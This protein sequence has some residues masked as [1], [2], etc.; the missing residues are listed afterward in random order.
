MLRATESERDPHLLDTASIQSADR[1]TCAFYSTAL[2]DSVASA[3]PRSFSAQRLHTST[4][5]YESVYIHA[6][7]AIMY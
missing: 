6:H 3:K 1:P 7:E 4:T 5:P 2:A